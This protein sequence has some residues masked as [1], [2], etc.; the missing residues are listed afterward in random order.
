MASRAPTSVARTLAADLRTQIVSGAIPV[1]QRIAGEHELMSRYAVSRQTV[2]EALR[3]L[4]TEGLVVSRRGGGGGAFVA[5][6][7]L[8]QLS[9]MMAGASAM[10]A[11]GAHFSPEEVSIAIFAIEAACCRLA[12]ARQDEAAIARMLDAIDAAI[13]APREPQAFFDAYTA[14]NHALWQASGNGPLAFVM[15]AFMQSLRRNLPPPGQHAE[16]EGLRRFLQSNHRLI[17]QAIAVA[18][19]ERAV[20]HL[21]ENLAFWLR[22]LA[23]DKP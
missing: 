18:D 17:H 9:G 3:E 7:D 14:F 21:R 4:G 2:R 11:A 23:D 22:H 5:A 20:L 19:G 6:P 10:I 13:L 16:W 15:R 12:A 8:D 1:G